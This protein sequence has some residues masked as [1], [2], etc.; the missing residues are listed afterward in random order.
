MSSFEAFWSPKCV[1][2]SQKIFYIKFNQISSFSL[3]T[4]TS[5]ITQEFVTTNL[6][7][8]ILMGGKG[9]NH[10]QSERDRELSWDFVVQ[11]KNLYFTTIIVD[12]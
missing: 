11:Q 1:F 7:L 10:H 4:T 6:S 2:F 3:C 9:F 12:R 8:S 5:M